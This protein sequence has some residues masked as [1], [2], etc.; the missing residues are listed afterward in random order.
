MSSGIESPA[1]T[2][3]A[4]AAAEEAL[5]AT[6]GI[7][8]ERHEA[9]VRGIR[10]HYLTCGEGDPLLLLHAR[11]DCAALFAPIFAA[12]ASHRRVI[13]L[14][15][16]GWGLSEKPPFTGHTA[17]D[18]LA[19]WVA[20]VAGFLDEQGLAAVDLLGHS[21]GGFIALGLALA[22][23]ERIQNLILV[24]SGGLGSEIQHDVRLYFALGPER[25]HRLL[26]R[27]FTKTVMRLGEGLHPEDAA[28]EPYYTLMRAIWTQESVVP[29]GAAAFNR[30]INMSGVHLILRDR[31]EELEM[32]VLLLWGDRDNVMPYHNA[33]VAARFLRDGTLV[34]FTGCGHA[35]FRERPDDFARVLLTWLQ[36]IYVPSRV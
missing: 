11:G 29:S 8:V 14:D 36:G 10:L 26:G 34:A 33:L 31:L 23:P 20:A 19:F 24:G 25:L 13:A 3:D 7:T 22:N 5:L 4:L 15:L 35:P 12:L 30:W 9:S 17:E 1:A 6:T 2:T 18:A 21:M 28:S 32:P 16:P 27:R